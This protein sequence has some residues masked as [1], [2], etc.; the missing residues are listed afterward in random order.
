MSLPLPLEPHI[1]QQ[2]DQ[3]KIDWIGQMELDVVLDSAISGGQLSIVRIHACRGDASPVH[4]HSRDDEAFLLIEGQMTVW[5][6]DTRTVLL[7]GGIGYLPREI[8]H[9]FRFDTNSVALTLTTPAGQESFFRQ[10][11]WDL[12]RLRPEGWTIS[13]DSLREAA[14]ANGVSVVAPPHGLED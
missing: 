7:P 13:P 14:A 11:G 10:A 1:A 8:P 3:Q 4:V 9:A 6:G 5:V 2:A 12:S